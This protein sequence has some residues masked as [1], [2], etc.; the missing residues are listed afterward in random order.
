[1][2]HCTLPVCVVAII[3]WWVKDLYYPAKRNVA[4]D[5]KFTVVQQPNPISGL[6]VV[7]EYKVLSNADYWCLVHILSAFKKT[8]YSKARFHHSSAVL[9]RLFHFVCTVTHFPAGALPIGV[10]FYMTV[11]P[12]LRQGFSYLGEDSPRDGRVLGVK[13]GHMAGYASCWSTCLPRLFSRLRN[14]RMYPVASNRT[15]KYQSFVN[16]GLLHYQ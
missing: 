14:P 8:L 12:H 7:M 5:T 10:K 13:R 2:S 4:R 9:L 15:K 6:D 1:M 3:S 11:R 16:Y